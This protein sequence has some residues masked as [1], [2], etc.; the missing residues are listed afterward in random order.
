MF[1][2]AN[3][4]S[5]KDLYVT[6]PGQLLGNRYDCNN[7]SAFSSSSNSQYLYSQRS[8]SQ[9]YSQQFVPQGSE[10]P[11]SNFYQKYKAMSP[12]F[13]NENNPYRSSAQA[14]GKINYQQQL[15]INKAK[16][17]DRDERDLLDSIVTTVRE[18]TQEVTG[19]VASMKKDIHQGIR[20]NDEKVTDMLEKIKTDMNKNYEKLLKVLEEREQDK[21]KLKDMEKSL[22][23]KDAMISQLQNDLEKLRLQKEEKIVASLK[24]TYAEQQEL[25]RQ[26]IHQL[27]QA[28][29]QHIEEQTKRRRDQTEGQEKQHQQLRS[30]SRKQIKELEHKVTQELDTQ[31]KQLEHHMREITESYCQLLEH[32]HE[33]QKQDL[34]KWLVQQMQG[35]TQKDTAFQ[36]QQEQKLIELQNQQRFEVQSYI[37]EQIRQMNLAKERQYTE[38]MN[39]FHHLKER[40]KNSLQEKLNQHLLQH[41]QEQQLQ[42]QWYEKKLQDMQMKHK[43]EIRRLE[44]NMHDQVS[45]S[46]VEDRK[47]DHGQTSSLSTLLQK[48][49]HTS[50]GQL[51]TCQKDVIASSL[52][53]TCHPTDNCNIGSYNIRQHDS[54]LFS[55]EQV[56][57][58]SRPPT[59]QSTRTTIASQ[60]IPT[61][62][63]SHVT[64]P[65][66]AN[67]TVSSMNQQQNPK[68]AHAV[69]AIS[70]SHQQC[71]MLPMQGAGAVSSVQG[72]ATLVPPMQAP[73]IDTLSSSS[74]TTTLWPQQHQSTFVSPMPQ[75]RGTTMI[76]PFRRN[77]TFS[78]VATV[79]PQRQS[80]FTG[81]HGEEYNITS[82]ASSAV[83]SLNNSAMGQHSTVNVSEE[84]DKLENP[85]NRKSL[86][87]RSPKHRKDK[88]KGKKPVKQPSNQQK[89]RSELDI[90]K[91]NSHLIVGSRLRQ[92]GITS[93]SFHSEVVPDK[94]VNSTDKQQ[95]VSM[96]Q[97]S[98][99]KQ[100]KSKYQQNYNTALSERNLRDKS[101]N[102][103]QELHNV[104]DKDAVNTLAK[105]SGMQYEKT[106]APDKSS[107][108]EE[109]QSTKKLFVNTNG[110]VDKRSLLAANVKKTV[111][112]VKDVYDFADEQGCNSTESS[113]GILCVIPALQGGLPRVKTEKMT[114]HKKIECENIEKGYQILDCFETDRFEEDNFFRMEASVPRKNMAKKRKLSDDWMDS[115]V[116]AVRQQITMHRQGTPAATLGWQGE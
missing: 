88:G 91:E 47:L 101:I 96:D 52:E 11:R 84:Q 95:E 80:G 43:E 103:N 31:Q 82:K 110:N 115:E 8:G 15:Q 114:P 65:V 10:S 106:G 78:P 111:Q 64:V 73:G 25:N 53:D 109:T 112:N 41:K 63:Q 23:A 1:S 35:K 51:V 12:L 83:Q 77:S 90:I 27:H 98:D 87:P 116:M 20:T 17:R 56:M 107:H 6:N 79:L 33:Q 2:S 32:K 21:E 76:G 61:I 68:P 85:Q 104:N 86:A 92:R 50:T 66:T 89:K 97:T 14:P 40:D 38:Q 9:E 81:K 58:N 4:A 36:R 57:Y 44:Q 55:K 45:K 70:N 93:N 102:L 54:V 16:A 26:Q 18:C 5:T 22:T 105:K 59:M 34:E 75:G 62:F 67:A 42:Y 37:Q 113:P 29:V 108:R 28:Q 46:V 60:D 74:S 3:Q 100:K 99:R 30:E 71:A 94:V 49:V 13:S 48:P 19:T 69:D 72:Q 7:D 24:Q 39:Q